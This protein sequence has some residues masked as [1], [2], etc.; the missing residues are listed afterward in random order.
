MRTSGSTQNKKR[1]RPVLWYVAVVGVFFISLLGRFFYRFSSGTSKSRDYC[2]ALPFRASGVVSYH[3]VL[4]DACHMQS[5]LGN[6]RVPLCLS[7]GAVLKCF[8]SFHSHRLRLRCCDRLHRPLWT[9]T[10]LS[11]PRSRRESCCSTRGLF[12]RRTSG[13]LPRKRR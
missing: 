12:A 4:M 1:V 11:P 2:Q 6:Y 8:F 3:T 13:L 9:C 5:M 10:A 7:F